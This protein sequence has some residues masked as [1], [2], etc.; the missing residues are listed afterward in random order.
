MK[1]STN[2]S[3]DFP[4]GCACCGKPLLAGSVRV[5]IDVGFGLRL[6]PFCNAACAYVGLEAH[7]AREARIEGHKP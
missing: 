2:S 1:V 7:R 6:G 3:T 5:H 4:E